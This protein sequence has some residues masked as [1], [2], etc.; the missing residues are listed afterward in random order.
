MATI[1]G[2]QRKVERRA[3]D[4]TRRRLAFFPCE[5]KLRAMVMPESVFERVKVGEREEAERVLRV[6]RLGRICLRGLW[7]RVQISAPFADSAVLTF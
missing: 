2:Q 7:I 5:A 4:G 1:W 3:A 6:E